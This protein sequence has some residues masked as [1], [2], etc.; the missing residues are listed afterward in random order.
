MTTDT[1]VDNGYET[2]IAEEPGLDELHQT[3]LDPEEAKKGRRD[4]QLKAGWWATVPQVT[5]NKRTTDKMPDAQGNPRTF[6]SGRVPIMHAQDGDE[7]RVEIVFSHQRRNATNRETGEE[8]PKPDRMYQTYLQ[9][10]RVYEQVHKV[11]PTNLGEL[12]GFLSD[13]PF[14]VRLIQTSGLDNMVVGYRPVKD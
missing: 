13:F 10:Y 14:E 7:G 2:P 6:F 1:I 11:P 9:L 5:W 4:S 3:A 8:L 12:I